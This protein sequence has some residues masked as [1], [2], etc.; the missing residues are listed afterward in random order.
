[1]RRFYG[2]FFVM[3]L[4]LSPA[5]ST[6]SLKEDREIIQVLR[7]VTLPSSEVLY[8]AI[9]EAGGTALFLQA[10]NLHL[11]LENCEVL[12]YMVTFAVLFSRSDYRK[13]IQKKNWTPQWTEAAYN[14]FESK[15]PAI[16]NAILA[17]GQSAAPLPTKSCAL[18]P[19]SLP[20]KARRKS[21]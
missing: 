19:P 13:Y 1:M 6:E 11:S 17:T 21:L 4:G 10:T 3:M 18:S 12:P 16:V 14:Y 2:V 8:K 15:T 7:P 5:H 9:L 20:Y